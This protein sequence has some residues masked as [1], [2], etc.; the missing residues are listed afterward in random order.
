VY[1]AGR[2]G[3]VHSIREEKSRNTIVLKYMSLSYYLMLG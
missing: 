1:S 3:P 2:R